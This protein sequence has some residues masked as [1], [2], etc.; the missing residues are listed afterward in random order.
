MAHNSVQYND[1]TATQFKAMQCCRY[2]VAKEQCATSAVRYTILYYDALSQF[3]DVKY[4]CYDA[5]LSRA[6]AGERLMEKLP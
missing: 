1:G 6:I 4:N 3:S 5:D 2:E